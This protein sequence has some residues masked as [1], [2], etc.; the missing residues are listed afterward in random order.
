M[1]RCAAVGLDATAPTLRELW[2]Q[3]ALATSAIEGEQLKDAEMRAFLDW[4]ARTRPDREK[5]AVPGWAHAD[6]S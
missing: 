3:E 1:G 4:L 6:R 5:T 2:V